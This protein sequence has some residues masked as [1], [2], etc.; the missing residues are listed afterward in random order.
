M[1]YYKKLKKL[2]RELDRLWVE[3]AF[4]KYGRKCLICGKEATEVHHFIPKSLSLNLRWDLDN[5]VP[6]CRKCHFNLHNRSDPYLNLII[7]FIRGKDWLD[8]IIKKRK[9]KVKF[10]LKYL[11]KIKKKLS[12]S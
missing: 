7:V 9:K 5:A 3:K 1:N 10:N 2:K 8:R 12:T 6:I 11:Q 4:E